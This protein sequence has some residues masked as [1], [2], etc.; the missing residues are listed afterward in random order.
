LGD[1]LARLDDNVVPDIGAPV[2]PEPVDTTVHSPVALAV[3]GSGT[4]LEGMVFGGAT[5]VS[6][7]PKA[8]RV[9]P[10]TVAGLR[11]V[12]AAARLL[13]AGGAAQSS[14]QT[15]VPS[16]E[17][18]VTRVARSVAASV[19]QRGGA[20]RDRVDGF[21]GALGGGP[22]LTAGSSS[23]PADTTLGAGE[24]VVLALPN[25]AHDVVTDGP[26]PYLVVK[27]TPTR[28]VA[29]RHGGEVLLDHTVE[30]AE[31]EIPVGAER[32]AVAPIGEGALPASA[33]GWHAGMTL[34]YV[35]WGTALGVDA[36]VRVQ[37]PPVARRGDRF[38]AG[39]VEAAEL[40]AGTA[41]VITRFSRPVDVVVVVI[42]D[43]V[44][45]AG[46]TLLLGLDGARQAVGDDGLP[47]PPTTVLAGNRAFLAYRIEADD[48]TV[49]VSVTVA[50]GTGWHVVGVLGASGSPAD[51]TAALAARGIDS[52]VGAAVPPGRGE[53]TL[54]WLAVEPP[55]GVAPGR[56]KTARKVAARKAAAK[57]AA[58][59]VAKKQAAKKASRKPAKKVAKKQAAEKQASPRKVAKKAAPAKKRPPRKRS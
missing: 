12:P 1:R 18:A 15:V 45:D 46:R 57:K 36:A 28:L 35:G 6:D 9:A 40:V 49:P 58:K 53:V 41:S 30:E 20:G 13:I 55:I 24:L 25:A 43:P 17:P 16:G 8:A 5:T 31:L 29:L 32:L 3:L 59:K 42:D 11:N 21:T 14:D 54:Q 19:A 44:A 52:M 23:A 56:Q 2:T 48:V 10:P 39:W 33:A 7:R 37:G 4:P 51:V 22:I 26:R 47:L 38:R 50:S 27:G 34:P